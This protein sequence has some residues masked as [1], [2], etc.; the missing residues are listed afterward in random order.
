M[1]ERTFLSGNIFE[2]IVLSWLDRITSNEVYIVSQLN[3]RLP[4]AIEKLRKRAD[5]A[6]SEVLEDSEDW[7]VTMDEEGN[8]DMTHLASQ[9]YS[10]ISYDDGPPTIEL[11]YIEDSAPC[12]EDK[13]LEAHELK[14]VNL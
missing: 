11:H 4:E 7:Y 14:V 12:E 9:T 3:D 2:R 10:K 8:L 6:R 13:W 5:E 1:A